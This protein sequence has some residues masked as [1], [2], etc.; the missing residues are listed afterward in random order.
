MRIEI[1]GSFQEYEFD[2]DNEAMLSVPDLVEFQV[3][4]LMHGYLLEVATSTEAS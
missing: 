2:T 1:F 3:A 4:A